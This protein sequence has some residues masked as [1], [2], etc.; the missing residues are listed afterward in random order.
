MREDLKAAVRSLL[1]S[2]T[3]TIVALLV[4]ALG[5]GASTAIFSVVDAVIL[6]SLPYD[7]HDRLVAVIERDTRHPTTFGDGATTPQLY[8]DWRQHQQPFE[9]VAATSPGFYQL[10]TEAGEPTN[11]TSESVTPEFFSVLHV[12]PMLGRAF[13]SADE[14]ETQQRVAILS[15]GFWQRQFGGAMDVVGKRLEL[16]GDP[17]EIVGVMP[18]GF[19][20]P[21][22]S[23]KPT[24]LYVPSAFS[25]NDKV[26]GDSHNFNNAVIARLR[27]G[28]SIAQASLQMKQLNDALD[29]EF[30][31][32][33]PGWTTEVLSLHERLVGTVRTWM[34][35]LLAVVGLVL[36]IACANVANLMLARAT[37]RS[38]E[39]AIRA[40]LGASRWRLIR[41]LIVEG[42][43]LSCLGAALGVLLAYGGVQV[44]RLWLPHNVPRLAAIAID[45]RV[46]GTTLALAVLTGLVFGCV[47]ARHA[48]K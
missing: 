35:M 8:L 34:L 23:D 10:H 45:L 9:Q 18:R 21:V 12:A 38:R 25:K 46:L 19:T 26:H 29:K 28:V 33:R 20:Y 31:K 32:F 15:Y 36:A 14:A 2:P 11:A 16:N 27:P 44:L 30:P 5:I 39:I 24:E 17:W 41:G 47:P 22:G 4:L 37:V 48:A 43:T 1:Q 42:L 40:A 13:T 3:F 6:K 7:E